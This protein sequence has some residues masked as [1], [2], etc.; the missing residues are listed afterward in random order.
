VRSC[1]AFRR[2][3][4]LFRSVQVS[5]V[6]VEGCLGDDVLLKQFG[7]TI[8]VLLR[9]LELRIRPCGRCSRLVERGF[10]F[11]DFLFSIGERR[12][13]LVNDVLVWFR[14]NTEKDVAF[15]KQRVYPNRHFNHAPLY[16]GQYRGHREVDA[17]VG[18]KGMIV[19]HNKKQQKNTDYSTQHRRGKRPL[20]DR[21]SEE[22]EDGDANCN[23]NERQ[24]NLHDQPPAFVLFF[25]SSATLRRKSSISVAVPDDPA[26][27]W[28][29]PQPRSGWYAIAQIQRNGHNT[30]RVN[31]LTQPA[32]WI[33]SA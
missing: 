27:V 15:L 6:G 2:R 20:V 12:F 21:D 5:G 11:I 30:W 8:K 22:L 24:Q 19:V 26:A 18:R 3:Q 28:E 9:Q 23:V 32:A 17:R 29:N 16:G 13:L 25:S 7:L 31:R 4:G 10:E 33:A 1:S 14:F